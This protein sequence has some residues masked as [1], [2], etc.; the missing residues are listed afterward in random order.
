MTIAI[1][2][3]IDRPLTD[4]EIAG[5]HA[6]VMEPDQRAWD[7]GGEELDLPMVITFFREILPE[8]PGQAVFLAK[9]EGV[10]VGMAALFV[11]PG[12]PEA[13]VGFGV[14]ATHQR[15]GIARRLLRALVAHARTVDLS[16]LF[17]EV[18]PHNLRAILLLQ[19]EGFQARAS[20][21]PADGPVTLAE[22][23][24]PLLLG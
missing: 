23:E 13:R 12:H 1:V 7:P 6:L 4:E 18:Y 17:A 22:F 16:G 19:S 11:T 5:F 15:K 21:A 2:S 8:R 10:V 14:S 20:T 9:S 3:T 24:M